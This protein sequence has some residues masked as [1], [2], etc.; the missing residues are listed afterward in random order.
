[1]PQFFFKS[2]NLSRS[3]LKNNT[4]IVFRDSVY[5]LPSPALPACIV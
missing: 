3:Y 5:I 1:M 4:G 2:A